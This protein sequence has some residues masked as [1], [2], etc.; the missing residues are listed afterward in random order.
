VTS[1]ASY[2]AMGSPRSATDLPQGEEDPGAA[3]RS[4]SPAHHT[5]GSGERNPP[6]RRSSC[7]GVKV[8]VNSLVL[9]LDA[10]NGGVCAVERRSCG[11][12]TT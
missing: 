10:H 5:L 6:D 1:R 7:A 2:S 8:Q 12:A 3:A 9:M 4:S 11:A